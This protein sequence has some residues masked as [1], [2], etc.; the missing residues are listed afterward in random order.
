M[1]ASTA[2]GI[3]ALRTLLSDGPTDKLASQKKLLG[4]ING[5]NVKFKTF[6][7]RRIT[8]FTTAI[9]PLG[10]YVNG[11]LQAGGAI[12]GDDTATGV[13]TLATAP[14]DGTEVAASYYYQWFLDSELDAFLQT[15]SNWLLSSVTYVGTPGGLI[16]SALSYAA[17]EAFHKLSVQMSI[18]SSAAYRLEDA[19]QKDVM[20]AAKSFQDIAKNFEERAIRQRDDFYTRQGQANQPLS[21]YSLG[22]LSAVTPRR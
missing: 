20:E 13:V 21:A 14:M 19:P 18:R 3:S 11:S 2:D 12:S 15:S 6:E 7:A 8:N 16:P 4:N 1:W 22:N 5:S 9:A 17:S 10:V